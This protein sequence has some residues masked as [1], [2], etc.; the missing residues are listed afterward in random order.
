MA[1]RFVVTTS[2]QL[3][4]YYSNSEQIMMSIYDFTLIL[5]IQA[6]PTPDGVRQIKAL[7]TVVMSPQHMK[8]LVNQLA[9]QLKAYEDRWGP[10]P[11]PKPGDIGV[12]ASGMGGFAPSDSST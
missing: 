3:P 2:E 11:D 7:A 10:I 9:G 6:P 1:D 8:V 5:G 4:A 12:Q